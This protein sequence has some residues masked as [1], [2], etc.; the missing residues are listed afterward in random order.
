M[1]EEVGRPFLASL[2]F[3]L[4]FRSVPFRS[5]L[6]SLSLSSLPHLPSFCALLSHYSHFEAVDIKSLRASVGSILELA[7]VSLQTITEL[8]L[9]PA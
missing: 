7:Q 8:A 9:Q 5:L 3:R 2:R 4:H 1:G 6:F